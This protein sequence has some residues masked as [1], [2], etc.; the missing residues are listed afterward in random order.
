MYVSPNERTLPK[1]AIGQARIRLSA[2]VRRKAV[3]AAECEMLERRVATIPANDW[4]RFES[5][6]SQPAREIPAN[7]EPAAQ[8]P[9]WQRYHRRD[10]STRPTPESASDFGRCLLNNWF[11]Q[12]AW[13]TDASGVSSTNVICDAG[14][15]E[16]VGCS[17]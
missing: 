15:G 11:R 8:A 9:T 4:E 12:R 5:C 2:F 14:A 1:T 17:T 7:K 13:A 3:D 10:P 6:A 16:I